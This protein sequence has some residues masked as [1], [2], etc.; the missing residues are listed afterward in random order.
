MGANPL[1][2]RAFLVGAAVVDYQKRNAGLLP[3][4]RD[5]AILVDAVMAV[6]LVL[7]IGDALDRIGGTD[8]R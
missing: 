4:G 5:N 3:E 7:G 2:D 8:E 6:C 1:K